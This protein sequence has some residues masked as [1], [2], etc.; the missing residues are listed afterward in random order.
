MGHASFPV[1]LH[2]TPAAA[3]RFVRVVA[4]LSRSAKPPGRHFPGIGPSGIFLGELEQI[5]A[6]NRIGRIAGET[7][8][9]DSLATRRESI[10]G[11]SVVG[12]LEILAGDIGS[13]SVYVR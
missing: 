4:R 3:S 5:F 9:S 7:A 1:L 6:Q 10:S 11:P 12:A 8:P 2:Q 13:V